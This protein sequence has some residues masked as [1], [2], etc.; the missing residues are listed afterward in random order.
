MIVHRWNAFGF[1]HMTREVDCSIAET[2]HSRW[3]PTEHLMLLLWMA[4]H[5][6]YSVPVPLDDATQHKC[7]VAMPHKCRLA[8]SM[9]ARQSATCDFTLRKPVASSQD[10][11]GIS[12]SRTGAQT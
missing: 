5:G 12:S 8:E 11:T 10:I 9:P 7:A 1:G 4:H 2:A 6:L 3:R